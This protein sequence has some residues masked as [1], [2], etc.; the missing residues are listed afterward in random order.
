MILSGV[1]LE[2]MVNFELYDYQ[3]EI[4][5][6]TLKYV[7]QGNIN[8]AVQLA[9]RGGKGPIMAKLIEY[10][11]QD[12][13]KIAFFAHTKILIK[14][15]SEELTEHGIKHGILAAGHPM[16]KYRVQVVSKDTLIR[17]ADKLKKSGWGDFD[18]IFVD[19]SHRIMGKT[20]LDLI[21]K[22]PEAVVLGFSATFIRSDGRPFNSIFDKIICGP[23]ISYLQE[24]GRYAKFDIYIPEIIDTKGIRT[25]GG[26]FSKKGAAEAVDKPTIY[27]HIPEHWEKYAKGKKTLTFCSSIDHADHVCAEFNKHGIP[28]IT[29]SSKDPDCVRDAK[30]KDYYDNKYINLV[31][32]NLFI[33]GFHIKECECIIMARL[34]KSIIVFLQTAGRAA[35]MY[36]GKNNV[37]YLDCVGNCLPERGL[38]L[39]TDDREWTLGEVDVKEFYKSTKKRCPECQRGDVPTTAR[40][41]PFCGFLWTE[42]TDPV[43][44]I[45]EQVEGELVK[46]G[47]TETTIKPG[48]NET[49][50]LVARNASTLKK[51]CSICKKLGYS[52]RFGYRVWV[53]DLKN[54]VRSA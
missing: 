29:I 46:I 20:Y 41:C 35:M 23:Q 2:V 40:E 7:K 33:E 38:G 11:I 18:Y 50:L 26:D 44:R 52:G 12:K 8:I 49:V 42:T 15:M 53:H 37:I 48:H 17:R 54:K 47:N 24:I 14:Q 21:D 9:T 3:E 27:G 19:E 5:Q 51:A 43:S 4:Y 31:S 6:K 16:I 36:P 28:S 13:K 1:F 30:V 39:P 10:L 34:T 32:V 22:Y 25:V 45:P